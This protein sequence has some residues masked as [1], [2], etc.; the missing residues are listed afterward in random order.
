MF[1][2][3]DNDQPAIFDALMRAA[4]APPH[5]LI[6]TDFFT[7]YK[8]RRRA[9]YFCRQFVHGNSSKSGYPAFA[10]RLEPAFLLVDEI[11]REIWRQRE[12]KQAAGR[13]VPACQNQSDHR[14]PRKAAQERTLQILLGNFSFGLPYPVVDS[15]VFPVYADKLRPIAGR[16]V[17]V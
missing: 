13:L 9:V 3:V 16:F 4:A 6:L 12:Q 11:F 5:L 17:S 1:G 7:A 14:S 15:F 8:N 10:R 2:A